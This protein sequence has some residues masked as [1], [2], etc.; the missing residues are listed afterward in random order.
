MSNSHNAVPVFEYTASDRSGTLTKGELEATDKSAASRQLSAQ[1]LFVLELKPSLAAAT[2]RPTLDP[3]PTRES[4]PQSKPVSPPTSPQPASPS[5]PSKNDPPKKKWYRR[6]RWSTL[7][8]AIYLRQLS[9][10]FQAGIP[11]HRAAS[12]VGDSESARPEVQALLAEIPRDLERGR[13]LSKALEKSGLFGRLVISTVRLGEESGRLEFV[14]LELADT[15]EEGLRLRR[16]LI[17]RL[18]YPVVVLIAM[19]LGLVVMG[20]VMG[21]VMSSLPN[22]KAEDVPLF[23]LVNA[24][25]ASKA[26]LP[27][28]ILLV[29]ATVLLIRY[30][31]GH[32][33]LRLACERRLLRIPMLGS[34]IRRLEAGT[35]TRQLSLLLSAGLTIDR[36]MTLCAE[37][38][39][40]EAFRSG[41]EQARDELR[42]GAELSE[43]LRMSNLF[44]DDVIALLS[45]GELSGKLEDSLRRSADYSSEQVE[46][47]LETLLALLEPLMIA[48]LGITI[49]IVLLCTFVP[50][51]NSLQ[52]L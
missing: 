32:R 41:L 47:S 38:A 9:V 48:F 1:G 12:V 31:S 24:I 10:M 44:P 35:I 13:M 5:Q 27:L 37:T 4:S 42:S 22:L 17:S 14:L 49:G 36:G 11:I 15:K 51:F 29:V 20:H 39:L 46:R 21:Q 19:S 50:V 40:T 2:P 28:L 8:E 23:G 3:L 52:T 18:T 30:I 45:A 34:L 25:F 16:T 26:F 6:A 43:S 7:D 33:E